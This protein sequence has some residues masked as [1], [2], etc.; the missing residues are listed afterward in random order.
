[1]YNDEAFLTLLSSQRELLNQLNAERQA[2]AINK[3]GKGNR[4]GDSATQDNNGSSRRSKDRRSSIDFLFSKRL[5]LGL[6]FDQH[7]LPS[8]QFD[9]ERRSS[10]GFAFDDVD[11][12]MGESLEKKRSRLDAE[13]AEMSCRRKKRRL[14]SLG[15]LSSTFFEDHLKPGRRDSL[16]SL[17]SPIDDDAEII[18][19]VV[20]HG[21]EDDTDIEQSDDGSSVDEEGCNDTSRDL[22]EESETKTDN[23]ENGC[24]TSTTDH[25]NVDPQKLKEIIEAFTYAMERSQKSQQNIH[26]W[27][28]KMGL[29]RSHS[30]T[31][32]QSTRSRKKLRSLLKKDINVL[33]AKVA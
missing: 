14:S 11:I 10:L 4:K 32:R 13:V 16:F 20:V 9:S 26:D 24:V 12:T 18:E 27:D 19:E 5:S 30:K 23:K 25:P 22:T 17:S 3:G 21:D 8:F 2:Q 31:M 28:R 6:G 1:M 33:A 7:V 29:K 15:F